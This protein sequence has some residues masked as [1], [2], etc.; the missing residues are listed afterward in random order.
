MSIRINKDKCRGCLSCTQV[1]PG[2]LIYEKDGAA[3]I[4]YPELCWGC[5][6]CVKECAFG[7]IEYFLGADIGG[8]GSTL[9][10]TKDK[11]LLKWNIE[12]YDG[13]RITIEVDPKDSN[14]Y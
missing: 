2:N 3:Y 7:A 8:R 5:V 11:G 1:C 4:R 13:S 14:K 12:K 10:V 6:S 9:N